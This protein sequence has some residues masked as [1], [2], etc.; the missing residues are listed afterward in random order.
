VHDQYVIDAVSRTRIDWNGTPES[1]MASPDK[2]IRTL[3]DFKAIERREEELI[4]D[5]Y[6]CIDCRNGY[7]NLALMR[8]PRD[9]YW[10]AWI[11]PPLMSPLLLEDLELAIIEAGGSLAQLGHYPLNDWCQ[12]KL[13]ASYLNV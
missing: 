10:E 6:W 1:V 11:I 4:A 3:E 7:A 2:V 8:S 9:E 5:G 13:R 12:T